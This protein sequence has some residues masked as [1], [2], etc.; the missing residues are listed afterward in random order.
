[1]LLGVVLGVL[2]IGAVVLAAASG[3]RI[4]LAGR[5]QEPRRTSAGGLVAGVAALVV[6]VAVV[7]VCSLPALGALFSGGPAT[8]LRTQFITWVPGLIGALVSVGI[9]YLAALGIGGLRP[10]GRGSEWLLLAFAP[11]LFVGTGPLS[12]A[13]WRDLY[14]LSLL[15]KFVGLI[16]PVLVSVPA[17]LVLTLLCKGLAERAEGDFVNGVLLPSLPMAGIMAGAVTLVNVAD[18]LWPL[19]AAQDEGLAVA[20][21]LLVK[22]LTSFLP[23]G[24]GL[25]LTPL[26]LVL[27]VA[28]VAVAAQLLYLDRL[29]LTVGRA[30]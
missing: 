5:A 11:W 20:P 15:D 19:L 14:N 26:V 7:V 2:G 17:L 27:V 28:A 6:V 16:P 21:V 29:R 10:L 22:R 24:T 18:L 25:S 30:R 12:I 4:T 9:A 1:T 8:A 23:P 13:F 3:M